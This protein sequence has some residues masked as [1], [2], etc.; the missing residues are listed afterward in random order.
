MSNNR[1]LEG[2]TRFLDYLG[3]K[4]LLNP[5]TASSRKAAAS[6]VFEIL[7]DEEKL[8]VIAV[9]LDDAMRRFH[10]LKGQSYSP[11]SLATYQ[12]RLK[13]A[14]EDFEKYLENPLGFRPS[15]QVRERK[16]KQPKAEKSEAGDQASSA[17]ATQFSTKE[18]GFTSS[19]ILPIPI[20]ADLI[21]RIQGLPFDLTVAEANKLASVIKAMAVPD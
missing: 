10:N 3:E 15:T 11:G 14:L 4:G 18:T 19:S 21:V 16:A 7:S 17:S 13:S 8:D 1:S 2:L 20:R 12:S 5:A 9:D 6:K